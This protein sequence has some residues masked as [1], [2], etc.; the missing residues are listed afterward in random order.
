MNR[1]TLPPLH[2][3]RMLR[4]CLALLALSLLLPLSQAQTDAGRPPYSAGDWA[5]LP[6]WCIDTQDGPY[7]SPNFSESP[8][9]KSRSPRSTRWTNIFG[10]EFWHMHHYCRAL[11]AERRMLLAVGE[12]AR[13]SAVQVILGEYRYLLGKCTPANPLLPEIYLRM[14]D[15]QLKSG[16]RIAAMEA[17]ENARK[18]KPDYWPPYVRWAEELIKLGLTSKARELVDEGLGHMPDQPDLLKLRKRLEGKS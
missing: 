15:V 18:L 11:Y 3:V 9:G 14:G 6:E 16:D 17:Y 8:I 1:T 13:R 5:L 10:G 12:A 2:T 7:G 4:R